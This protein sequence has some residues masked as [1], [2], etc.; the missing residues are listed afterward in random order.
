VVTG[1]LDVREA[2]RRLP[3]GQRVDEGTT[4]EDDDEDMA[5]TAMLPEGVTDE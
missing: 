1:K 2:A 5:E 3:E 4:G